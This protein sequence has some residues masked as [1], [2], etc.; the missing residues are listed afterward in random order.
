MGPPPPGVTQTGWM[1]LA[2]LKLRMAA[3][4]NLE[5]HDPETGFALEAVQEVIHRISAMPG[6]R[7]MVLVSPGFLL[8]RSGNHRSQEN[9]VLDHA[10]RANV[11]VNTID[12]RGLYTP[13]LDASEPGYQSASAA[14]ILQQTDIA[15]ASEKDDVLEEL[16][17]G[18]GGTFF[19]NDNGLK[20]G[21]DLD[22]G[23]AG[24]YLRAGILAAEFEVRWQLSRP[25]GYREERGGLVDSGAAGLLGSES[26]GQR[27]GAIQRRDSGS[28]L[29]TRRN[30]GHSSG[31]SNR[32]SFSN[33][34]RT[35]P[36]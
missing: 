2:A 19:H 9:D 5:F 17:D 14:G 32:I 33:P 16:A 8:T 6:S 10:I 7:S 12:M 3:H 18:T 20:E 13:M 24:I 1:E 4:Q 35:P 15:E 30:S 27:G 31:T 28:G 29:V 11:T 26:R 21:L 34:A 36:S 22:C 25:E 23:T